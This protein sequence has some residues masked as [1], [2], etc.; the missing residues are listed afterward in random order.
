LYV[1]AYNSCGNSSYT[2]LIQSTTACSN[3]N[4][5]GFISTV[6][7]SGPTNPGGGYTGDG[8]YAI[9][10]ELNWPVGITVDG[11]GN[12]YISDSQNN[13]VRKVTAS[14]GLISTI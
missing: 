10:A 14:T 12:M 4:G 2:K 3:C 5:S 9:T 13:R 11:D 6:A 7:G 8:I 1:W